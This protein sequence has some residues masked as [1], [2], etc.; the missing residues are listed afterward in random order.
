MN[1]S[2]RK[3]SQ[4][5]F[6][7]VTIVGR[8]GSDCEIRYFDNGKAKGRVNL[9][10]NRPSKNEQTDWFSIDFWDRDAEIA[11]EYV[12][13]GTLVCVEGRLSINRWTDRDGN[14]REAPVIICSNL[15]LLGSRNQNN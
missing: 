12:K 1:A 6:N 13:K 5:L 7:T 15:R 11:G 14:E 4:Y 2:Q 9:A 3:H 8:A 10:V